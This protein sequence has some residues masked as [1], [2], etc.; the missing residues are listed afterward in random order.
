MWANRHR[1]MLLWDRDLAAADGKSE[2]EKAK[3]YKKWVK[4]KFGS[5]CTH[6]VLKEKYLNFSPEVKHLLMRMLLTDPAKRISMEG[7]QVG[8]R[9]RAGCCVPHKGPWRDCARFQRW[10]TIHSL[11]RGA[12]SLCVWFGG[13]AWWL[14]VVVMRDAQSHPWYCGTKLSREQKSLVGGFLRGLFGGK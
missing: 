7:I 11:S 3:A 4:Q 2:K 14:G 10:P 1:D 5:E 8:P 9:C 6:L 12:T 13:A